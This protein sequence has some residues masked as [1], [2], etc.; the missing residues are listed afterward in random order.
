MPRLLLPLRSSPVSGPFAARVAAPAFVVIALVVM[1]GWPSDAST[2]DA[3]PPSPVTPF[4]EHQ[5]RFEGVWELAT[6]APRARRVVD[7]SIERTVAAMNFFVRGVARGQLRDNTPINRRITL[8]FESGQRVGVHFS[9]TNLRVTSRIGRTRRT[10]HDGTEIRVTQ[11]FRG[12]VL[13]QVFETD[14]G[15]R[16]NTYH[17]TGDGTLRLD[18]VTQGMMMPEALRFSLDYRRATR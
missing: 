4:D 15:T 8:R 10:Q 14:E 9:E 17:S 1:A 6:P 13:E 7:Q 16:W 5:A 12:D 18:A 11:R 2:Q 3:P